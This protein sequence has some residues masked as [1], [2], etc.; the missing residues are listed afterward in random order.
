MAAQDEQRDLAFGSMD[1]QA[2][3]RALSRDNEELT[4]MMQQVEARKTCVNEVNDLIM[5]D[6]IASCAIRG[7]SR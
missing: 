2:Q 4:L 7:S 6:P 1:A 5:Q 3:V